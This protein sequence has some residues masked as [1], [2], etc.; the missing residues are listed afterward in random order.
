MY[1]NHLTLD[2]S[3]RVGRDIVFVVD[4][5][6]NIGSSGF[7]VVGELI[8][9]ITINLKLNSPET[10]FGLITFD[11]LARFEFSITRY[12]DLSTLLPAINSG[13]PYYHGYQTNTASALRL[14]LSGSVEDGFLRLRNKTS[15]VAIVITDGHSSSFS[16]L[17]SAANS[18]H[19]AN[20][21]DVYAV[22]IGRTN[23]RALQI[24]ASNPSFVFSTR[25]L[26]VHTA[27]QLMEDVIEQLCSSK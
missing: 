21:Y 19:A 17:Q 11:S 2:C 10:L 3:R 24:I 26:T 18:L 1:I 13:L 15:K 9:N 5:S 7:Q 8:E 23:L 4:T 14:L 25:Y 27:Q 16:S 6:G 22:G 20:I 12:T